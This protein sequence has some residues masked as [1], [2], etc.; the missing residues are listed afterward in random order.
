VERSR[1]RGATVED[2]Q[3]LL[4]RVTVDLDVLA[5]K[6]CIRGMRI[7]VEHILDALVGGILPQQLLE[8]YP[9]LEPEDIKASLLYAKSV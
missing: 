8:E 3:A 5:G 6:P 7:S 2:H 4:E 1:E 9:M